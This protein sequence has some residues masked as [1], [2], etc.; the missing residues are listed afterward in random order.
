MPNELEVFEALNVDNRIPKADALEAYYKIH[1]A[2]C[3]EY[4]EEID[5]VLRQLEDIRKERLEFTEKRIPQIRK[6]LAEQMVSKEAID[7]WCNR[8]KA[9][10][11]HRFAVS[12]EFLNNFI[13]AKS[14]EFERELQTR[15]GKV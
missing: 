15:L 14:K 9:D 10:M 11:E 1:G 5:Y 13:I 6:N 8:L 4:H 3:R 7:D 12:E 2:L